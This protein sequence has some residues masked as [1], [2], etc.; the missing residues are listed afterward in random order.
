MCTALELMSPPPATARDTAGLEE[1]LAWMIDGA[2]SEVYVVDEADHLL[3]VVTDY[4][5]LK[6]Q[7]TQVDR[8]TPIDRLMCRNVATTSPHSDVSE[9]FPAFR[10]CRYRQMTVVQDG[11][12]IGVINRHDVLR[13]IVTWTASDANSDY[14]GKAGDDMRAPKFVETAGV[15]AQTA[16]VLAGR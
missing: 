1:V 2:M 8:A 10:D 14:R 16:A 3:G 6:A 4:D 15:D 11:R 12:L 13:A 5:L 7:F 9:L